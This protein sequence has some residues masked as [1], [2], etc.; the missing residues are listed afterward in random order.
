MTGVVST[1]PKI[2]A[3]GGLAASGSYEFDA[4]VD[5]GTVATRRYEADI[6]A[7]SFDT[8]DLISFRDLV[9]TWSSVSGAVIDDCDATLYIATTDDDPA[10]SPTW[11]DWVPFFVAD[12]TARAAK[13]KI[14]LASGSAT[15]NIAISTLAIDIKEPA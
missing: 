13:F 15:H 2:S 10:G 4:A 7:V 12:F 5:L 3:L 1:W 14:D 6:A 8:G 11:S 9:T